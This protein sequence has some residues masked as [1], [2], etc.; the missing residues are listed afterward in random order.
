MKSWVKKRWTGF[1]ILLK[2]MTP[3]EVLGIK[4]SWRNFYAKWKRLIGEGKASVFEENLFL[5]RQTS[6]GV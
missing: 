3:L 1:G 6:N 4:I 5:I 2:R